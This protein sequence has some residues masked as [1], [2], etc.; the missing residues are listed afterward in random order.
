MRCMFQGRWGKEALLYKNA[1]HMGLTLVPC[2]LKTELHTG[3]TKQKSIVSI[4]ADRTVMMVMIAN[5]ETARL[6]AKS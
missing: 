4:S 3:L 5:P 1:T 6:L 2:L